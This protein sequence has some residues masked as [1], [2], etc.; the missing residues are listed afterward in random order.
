M[1]RFFN[2]VISDLTTEKLMLEEQ[3]ETII[4]SKIDVDLKLS[5]VKEILGKITINEASLTKFVSLLTNNEEEKK[6][7]KNG[8][9]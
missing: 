6:E 3:L 1:E 8:I 2:L 7:E 5:K 4:N 9:I